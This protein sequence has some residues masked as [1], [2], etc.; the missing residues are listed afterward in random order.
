[1]RS[2]EATRPSTCKFADR[3]AKLSIDKFREITPKSLLDSLKQTVISSYVLEEMGECNLTVI[4]IGLGTKTL[5]RE[6]LKKYS[7]VDTFITSKNLIVDCH[8][9]NG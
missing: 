7:S 5:S 6:A 4:A 2:A 8:A 9:G 1:M 3:I